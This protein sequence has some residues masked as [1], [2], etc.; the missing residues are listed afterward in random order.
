MQAAPTLRKM[1]NRYY[2]SN[3][4][5]TVELSRDDLLGVCKTFALRASLVRAYAGHG[6][7]P[8]G[9]TDVVC[10]IYVVISEQEHIA[11]LRDVWISDAE[12]NSG[13]EAQ[14]CDDDVAL[15]VHVS[16]GAWPK[17]EQWCYPAVRNLA[18]AA[19]RSSPYPTA[20]P[21]LAPP[22]ETPPDGPRPSQAPHLS[23][24]PVPNNEPPETVPVPSGVA[25]SAR[26][27][28]RKAET[29]P[30]PPPEDPQERPRPSQAP[31]PS[32]RPRPSQAPWFERR[33]GP[34]RRRRKAAVRAVRRSSSGS[35]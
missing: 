18:P 21:W 26:P 6:V 9:G 12:T 28:K 14:I 20:A 33:C 13:F 15:I 34:H 2:V 24:L 10:A 3:P 35:T 8:R 25:P 32:P 1:L 19:V 4:N 11:E 23:S 22:A 29:P 31:R 30:S 5:T 27:P 17:V 16:G 7:L